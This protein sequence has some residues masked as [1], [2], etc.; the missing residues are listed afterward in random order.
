MTDN[1]IERIKNH[2]E[3]IMDILELE[4]NDSTKDTPFRVAKMWVN[5]IFKNRNNKNIEE[6]NAQMKLFKNNFCNDELIIVKD[7]EFSS[8]CE[9]HWLPF[10][11]KI[12]VGYVPTDKIIGLSK[13]PRVVKFFSQKPQ[14]QERLVHE[15][16]EYLAGIINPQVLFV[17]AKAI[18][19]CVMCRGAESNSITETSYVY[20]NSYIPI[21]AVTA[22][23]KEFILKTTK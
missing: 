17:S 12:S 13:I 9:H 18:H 20:M 3:E 10:T 1:K 21:E 16:G 22:Y 7:I 11:G 2:L 6:L 15:I 19:D 8:F 4:K 23:K 14:L 5:E